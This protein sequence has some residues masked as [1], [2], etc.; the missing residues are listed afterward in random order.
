MNG[1]TAISSCEHHFRCIGA[2]AELLRVVY[3]LLFI[4]GNIFIY[5]GL[6]N[7]DTFDSAVF[8]VYIGLGYLY[9]FIPLLLC[10]S[11]PCLVIGVFC[12]QLRQANDEAVAAERRKPL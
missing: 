5:I 11:W 4:F 9:L 2:V 8:V 1:V 7:F 6:A 12:L 3:I 10:V